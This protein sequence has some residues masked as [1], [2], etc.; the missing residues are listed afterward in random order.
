[1]AVPLYV[2]VCA[3]V[4]KLTVDIDTVWVCMSVLH[5]EGVST[6]HP[7]GLG[8]GTWACA[9]EGM[10]AFCTKG[11]L[12]VEGCVLSFLRLQFIATGGSWRNDKRSG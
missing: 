1:M 11:S 3:L 7:T 4:G 6:Q 9:P 8:T 2:Y 12:R 10:H 5:G